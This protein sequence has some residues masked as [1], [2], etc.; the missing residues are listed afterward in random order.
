MSKTEDALAAGK[1]EFWRK[2]RRKTGRA[3]RFNAL[4][5]PVK[6]IL[7]LRD[8]YAEDLKRG[9]ARSLALGVESRPEGRI[10]L[11]L[12]IETDPEASLNLIP[13]DYFARA[14]L[15]LLEAY[16]GGGTFPIATDEVLRVETVVEHIRQLYGIDGL[17]PVLAGAFA[18]QPPNALERLFEDY[19]AAYR[20]YM[21]DRRIFRD[22]ASRPAQDAAGIWCPRFNYDSF[23]RRMRYAESVDWGKRLF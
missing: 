7:L 1:S 3:L 9:G 18:A 8:L 16:P 15:A 11:P 13:V 14:F 22:S 2:F 20:P 12:R 23:A 6:A 17:Q 21:L 4:Y 10:L 5:Y 19:T